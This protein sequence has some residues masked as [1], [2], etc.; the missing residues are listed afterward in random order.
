MPTT[1]PPLGLTLHDPAGVLRR[2]AQRTPLHPHRLIGAVLSVRRQYVV[3]AV[4]LPVPVEQPTEQTEQSTRRAPAPVPPSTP[5]RRLAAAVGSAVPATTP[6]S[7][8]L[9]LIHCRPGRVVWLPGDLEWYDLGRRL[10]H[11]LGLRAA[12][13]V[14]V[15]E[16]GW[17]TRP[18]R[19]AG[20]TP[21]LDLR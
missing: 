18:N 6:D 19:T 4:V 21:A 12:D 17:R 8:A 1:I 9:L 16:H 15:T 11:S 20:T 13:Q 2:V 10:A 3:D 5:L 14:L 7:H